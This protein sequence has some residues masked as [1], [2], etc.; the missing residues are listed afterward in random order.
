MRIK[1]FLAAIGLLS[2]ISFPLLIPQMAMAASASM[3]LTSSGSAV[4]GSYVSVYVR[5]NSGSTAVNAARATLSY[6]T[7]KLQF[8]SIGS[9]SAF[10]IVAASSGGNGK[11]NIDRGA[12]PAVS[13]SQTIA[14]VT[15]RALTDSGAATVSITSGEVR[16]ASNNSNIA[17]SKTGTTISFKAPAPPKKAPPKDTKAPKITKVSVSQ[18]TYKSAVINWTTT[19]PATAE[20]SYGLS[21]GY[22]LA[23]VDNKLRT[24]HKLSLSS[25][26]IQP[27]VT[28]HYSIKS[29]DAAGNAVSTPDDTF[30]TVGAV[31][32]VTVLDQN[33]QPVKGASVS[34]DNKDDVTNDKGV[35]TI[36]GLTLGK[37][38]GVITYKGN[39]YSFNT[40]I[41]SAAQPA[42]VT[43]SVKKAASH[44]LLIVLLLIGLFILDYLIGWL[45]GRSGLAKTSMGKLR[46]KL[47]FLNKGTPDNQPSSDASP[48]VQP[49]PD[50]IKPQNPKNK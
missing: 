38:T 15:F 42:A 8:I 35:A 23:A 33:K 14:Y 4:K 21:K 28:Y 41:T 47:P 45:T 11:V 18:V 44:T 17:G 50:V 34:V 22:G 12:M 29:T 16:S 49:E 30:S 43:V 7:S 40:D 13:G 5:E 20:I 3:Y 39:K 36:E 26:L 2:T 27:G 6:P 1:N 48:S 31:L 37:K 10:S 9:S 19:E 32:L 24:D 25:P 46:A